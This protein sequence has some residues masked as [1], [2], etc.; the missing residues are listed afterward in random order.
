MH[1]PC[2]TLP[3]PLSSSPCSSALLVK[4]RIL[5]GVVLRTREA[6]V[7]WPLAAPWL[8]WLCLFFILSM[9][10]SVTDL[11][12]THLL[13]LQHLQPPVPLNLLSFRVLRAGW[14]VGG[15]GRGVGL[16]PPDIFPIF[17]VR[18]VYISKASTPEAAIPLLL[19]CL[20]PL[21]P[22]VAS[23]S[24]PRLSHCK[25]HAGLCGAWHGEDDG[26]DGEA[27]QGAPVDV[28]KVRMT[29]SH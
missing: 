24:H 17:P 18:K 10:C 5:G 4:H 8:S 14:G 6:E 11:S 21:R 22:V 12:L 28:G 7:N 25:V 29:G 26:V 9:C 1:L 20:Y 23:T 2:W 27:P 16:D 3:T 19:F 13:D 15:S